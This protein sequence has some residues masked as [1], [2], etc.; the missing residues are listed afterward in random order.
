M[1]SLVNDS[2]GRVRVRT[3]CGVIHPVRAYRLLTAGDTQ[4]SSPNA[5][6]SCVHS[7]ELQ[8]QVSHGAFQHDLRGCLRMRGLGGLGRVERMQPGRQPRVPG[9]Q[10]IVGS[11]RTPTD[12][13]LLYVAE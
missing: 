5:A 3:T 4:S 9:P 8:Q 6:R 2:F 1:G 10:G 13:Q 12:V 11:R 7:R